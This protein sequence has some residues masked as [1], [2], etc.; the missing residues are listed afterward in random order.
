[1]KRNLWREDDQYVAFDSSEVILEQ[2]L[3]KIVLINYGSCPQILSYRK[4][5]KKTSRNK[6]T[7]QM[8]LKSVHAL[9][10][11]TVQATYVS[12][13]FGFRWPQNGYSYNISTSNFLT[14]RIKETQCVI[15]TFT[16]AFY[17]EY[18]TSHRIY[19]S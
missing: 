14:F 19:S 11:S 17:L 8:W 6:P 12:K 3:I 13:S 2:N 5:E 1:M 7:S 18:C 15:G 9:K 10:Y 16:I 4:N